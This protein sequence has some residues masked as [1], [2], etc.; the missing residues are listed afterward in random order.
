[1]ATRIG[2]R[3]LAIGLFA[4]TLDIVD[5]LIFNVLRGITP[6]QVLQY[7]AS[8]LIG[9]ASFRGEGL[10]SADYGASFTAIVC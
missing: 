4:G 1:M 8:G 10:V 2:L 7:I 5:A 9:I 3:V 6:I